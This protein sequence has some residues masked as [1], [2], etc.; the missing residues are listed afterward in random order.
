LKNY[1][2]TAAL[3][4]LACAAH[5]AAGQRQTPLAAVPASHRAAIEELFV[6]MGAEREITAGVEAQVRAAVAREPRLAEFEPLMLAHVRRHLAWAALKAEFLAVYA[7]TYTEAEARQLT[8]FYRTP[9]GQ[10]T[11]RVQGQLLAEG[12]RITEA[13]LR[14]HAPELEAAMMAR[15]RTRPPA[16]PRAP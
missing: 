1:L 4:L 8:A 13:R 7:R 9:V 5:P 14:A 16:T 15:A 3:L 6:A 12:R 10:K 11:Q 2:W